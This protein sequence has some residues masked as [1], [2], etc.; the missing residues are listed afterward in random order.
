M[1]C[2]RTG[3]RRVVAP[4]GGILTVFLVLSE[5]LPLSEPKLINR[6]ERNATNSAGAGQCMVWGS[7]SKSC[8]KAFGGAKTFSAILP[9]EVADIT[10]YR[11]VQLTIHFGHRWR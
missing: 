3:L 4:F 8:R 9:A 2:R 7:G 6:I 5:L 10:R 11:P 1:V